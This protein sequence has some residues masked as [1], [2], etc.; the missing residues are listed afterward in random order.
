MDD[1]IPATPRNSLSL[2]RVTKLKE[3][4]KENNKLLVRI[5]QL[6]A[7]CF[8]LQNDN[9]LLKKENF[10]LKNTTNYESHNNIQIQP[11]FQTDEEE[12]VQETELNKQNKK[13]K[14]NTP[15]VT[16]TVLPSTSNANIEI[17]TDI[18]IQQIFETDED[19]LVKETEWIVK[20]HKKSKTNKNYKSKITSAATADTDHE[21][22]RTKKAPTHELRPPPI[23][24]SIVTPFNDLYNLIKENIQQSFTITLMK[25]F[26]KINVFGSDDYRNITK[27]LNNSKIPWHSYEDK[28]NRPFRVLA[29]NLHHS[30]DPLEIISDLKN[31]GLNILNAENKLKFRTKEPL[32]IFT[33]SFDS[34]ESP[35]KIYNIKRILNTI[36]RIEPIHHNRDIPQ[37]KKCQSFGHT[38][39]YCSKPPRCVKCAGKHESTECQKNTRDDPKC[40]NCGEKHPASYRGCVVPKELQ[41][42]RDRKNKL[43]K[44]EK[45][46]HENNVINR[47][48]NNSEKPTSSSVNR[49]TYANVLKPTNQSKT[50]NNN[51]LQKILNKLEILEASNSSIVL[52]MK[53][54]ENKFYSQCQ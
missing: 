25:N 47:N 29:K 36:V 43:N 26:H 11:G 6:E 24:V 48:E 32:D 13:R 10:K 34:A 9:F 53:T 1:D 52:R 12:P 23:M 42:I 45:E 28:Q 35:D 46:I 20:K 39:N 40:C 30:F 31:Q 22:T 51:V 5:K 3:L 18:E 38:R 54:L 50:D 44:L 16:E 4:E 17:Q 7:K 21:E 37:C 19:E 8:T 2:F 27:T 49:N 33:L 14:A 41:K 15:P